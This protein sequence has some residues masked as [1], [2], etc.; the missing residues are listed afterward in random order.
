MDVPAQQEGPDTEHGRRRSGSVCSKTKAALDKLAQGIK[1]S[2]ET[3]HATQTAQNMPSLFGVAGGAMPRVIPL[4][5]RSLDRGGSGARI[6]RMDLGVPSLVGIC[7]LSDVFD[8]VR[9]IGAAFTRVV[10]GDSDG[11]ITWLRTA[12]RE[13]SVTAG[14]VRTKGGGGC[15]S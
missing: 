9:G 7:D 4:P 1:H 8:G 13:G 2:A 6:P 10:E 12:A 11:E 14:V 5:G 3:I 15:C